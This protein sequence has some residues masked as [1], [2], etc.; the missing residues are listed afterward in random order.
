MLGSV[1]TQS[2]I[3]LILII[4][5]HHLYL[6]FKQNLTTPKIK[7][8]V[9][10]PLNNYNNIYKTINS[11][12]TIYNGADKN[13]MK[14]EL[15]QYFKTLNKTQH[16]IDR[17]TDRNTETFNY[18]INDKNNKNNNKNNNDI[19]EAGGSTIGSINY[20]TY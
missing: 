7:D 1:M 20:S 15:K 6:F 9:N 12:K 5:I 8:L 11:G 14:N 17:N 4:L 2:I 3:S 19:I 10:K 16:N 13:V 18:N